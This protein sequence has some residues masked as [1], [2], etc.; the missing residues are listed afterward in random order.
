MPES[1]SLHVFP[2]QEACLIYQPKRSRLN[3]GTC[4]CGFFLGSRDLKS[5]FELF[6]NGH[7]SSPSSAYCMLNDIHHVTHFPTFPYLISPQLLQV[8]LGFFISFLLVEQTSGS[9]IP[10]F[11]TE[12]IHSFFTAADTMYWVCALKWKSRKMENVHQHAPISFFNHYTS[13]SITRLC[14]FDIH[15]VNYF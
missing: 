5:K 14:T 13:Q 10:C 15:A 11:F 4:R 12:I 3:A 1:S 2:L 8:F 6:S 7:L 9:F